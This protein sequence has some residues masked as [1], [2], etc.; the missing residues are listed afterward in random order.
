[1]SVPSSPPPAYTAAAPGP[2]AAVSAPPRL[3]VTIGVFNYKGGVAKTTTLI[4][5]ACMLAKKRI[6]TMMV[7]ADPQCNLTTFFNTHV[8]SDPAYLADQLQQAADFIHFQASV[9][10]EAD[11]VMQTEEDE[12]DENG[13]ATEE[14]EKDDDHEV[15]AAV[16]VAPA[17]TSAAAKIRLLTDGFNSQSAAYPR[18][19]PAV[20]TSSPSLYSAL[21]P[22]FTSEGSGAVFQ[23]VQPIKVKGQHAIGSDD[24]LYLLPGSTDIIEYQGLLDE[25]RVEQR[26]T[27]LGCFRRLLHLIAEAHDIAVILVDFGPS[28]GALN[29]CFVM[30]CDYI[31]P[32]SFADIY[33]QASAEGFLNKVMVSWY[34]WWRLVKNQEKQPDMRQRL[35]QPG[36]KRFLFNSQAPRILPFLVTNYPKYDKVV[37]QDSA[38]WIKTLKETVMD[39]KVLD[40]IKQLFFPLNVRPGSPA[41][42]MV[43]PLLENVGALQQVSHALQ[44]PFVNFT[45]GVLR[46]TENVRRTSSINNIINKAKLARERYGKLATALSLLPQPTPH[47]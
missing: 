12:G 23:A 34:S 5:V 15:A 13:K 29:R 27:Y 14:D 28:S 11:T 6:R 47:P 44:I 38:S 22:I 18:T 36:L 41:G 42:L 40:V 35:Q 31:L 30:S 4:N 20:P 8:V 9:A 43:I 10:A 1:M 33:S 24:Y 19:G 39:T 21:R 32:P 26:L 3:P 37:A 7:D 2:A 45:K 16:F 46:G 25:P 17:V